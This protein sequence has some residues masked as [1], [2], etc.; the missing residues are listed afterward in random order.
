MIVTQVYGVALVGVANAAK[1]EQ[2]QATEP[3]IGEIVPLYDH[4]RQR[5]D[6]HRA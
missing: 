2:F 6:D 5:W 4:R 1:G 3:F